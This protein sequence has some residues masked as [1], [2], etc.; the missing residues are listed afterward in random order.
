MIESE[1]NDLEPTNWSEVDA[2]N[3]AID[4]GPDGI[5]TRGA[6]EVVR[7]TGLGG[8]VLPG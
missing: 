5:E 6:Y 4:F 2:T 7:L 8:A 1:S 3:Q